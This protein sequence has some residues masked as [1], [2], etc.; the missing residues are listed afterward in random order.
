MLKN[1]ADNFDGILEKMS[2]RTK[3][4]IAVVFFIVVLV[5]VFAVLLPRLPMKKK[6]FTEPGRIRQVKMRYM[7]LRPTARLFYPTI[8]SIFRVNILRITKSS[9]FSLPT[10]RQTA[11]IILRTVFCI[12]P[13][14]TGRRAALKGWMTTL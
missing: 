5:I 6:S 2:K 4:I 9:T 13:M 3:E 12:L 1:I 10:A 8:R 11:P 14:K 7:N